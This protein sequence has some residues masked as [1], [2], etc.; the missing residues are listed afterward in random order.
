M[1]G[2]ARWTW[3]SRTPGI[4]WWPLASMT[5]APSASRS[6][7]SA[8]IFSP[9]IPTSPANVPAGVTT[10]PPLIRRSTP[11]F[12]SSWCSVHDRKAEPEN[13]WYFFLV[14]LLGY[15]R[16]RPVEHVERE[17]H[18]VRRDAERRLDAKNVA[19]EAGLADEQAHLLRGLEDVGGFPLGGLLRLL[20]ADELDAEHQSHA[21]DVGADLVRLVEE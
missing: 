15:R 17:L 9:V 13:P 20:V 10:F 7:P 6:V 11:M 14:L 4:T 8:A 19:V 18:V 5:C 21:A 12:G 16:K 1:N 2:S 3:A